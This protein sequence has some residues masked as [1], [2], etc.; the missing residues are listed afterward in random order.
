M[1]KKLQQDII[2]EGFSILREHLGIAKTAIFLEIIGKGQG[3]SLE[4]IESKTKDF[5]K[6]EA[7]KFIEKCKKE[8]AKLW[9]KIK[10][11]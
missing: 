7:L 9:N 8:R 6:E 11:A 1:V 5:S 3:D 2:E 10:V 4:E